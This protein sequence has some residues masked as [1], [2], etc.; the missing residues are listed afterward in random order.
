MCWLDNYS[1]T[2]SIFGLLV[3]SKEGFTMNIIAVVTLFIIAGGSMVLIPYLLRYPQDF[4][5]NTVLKSILFFNV[6]FVMMLI[7]YFTGTTIDYV[8]SGIPICLLISVSVSFG[9]FYL[10]KAFSKYLL[11]KK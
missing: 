1:Y 10:A 5:L 6:F 11:K 2:R 8:F 4:L 3:C 9:S 7:P